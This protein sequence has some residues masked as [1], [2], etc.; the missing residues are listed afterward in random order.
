M[1]A[2]YI[3]FI[4][5]AVMLFIAIF[6][7]FKFINAKISSVYKNFDRF[8]E[9]VKKDYVMKDMCKTIESHQKTDIKR[10]EA[11]LDEIISLLMENRKTN[12]KD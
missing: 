10:L 8:K 1:L 4:T 11:K 6:G 9:D 5:L 3:S 7:I 12:D 2:L